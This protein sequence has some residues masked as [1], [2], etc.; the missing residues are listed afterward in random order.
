[1]CWS[2]CLLAAKAPAVQD[3]HEFEIKCKAGKLNIQTE[4]WLKTSSKHLIGMQSGHIPGDD[5][6]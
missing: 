1:M 4:L 5:K 3:D 2:T 6:H